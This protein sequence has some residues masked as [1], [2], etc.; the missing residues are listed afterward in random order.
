MKQTSPL[1]FNH[2]L[3]PLMLLITGLLVAWYVWVGILGA[4]LP[5]ETRLPEMPRPK[6]HDRV[7]VFAPHEDDETLGAGAYMRKAVVAGAQVYV[8]LMTAGEGEELGAALATKSPPL[9]P[10]AFIRLGQIRERETRQALALIGVPPSHIFFLDYPNRGLKAMWSATNWA[11]SNPWRSPYTRTAHSPLG[12]CFTPQAPFAGA[13]VVNDIEQVL[14]RVKP[15]QIFTIHPAD[16]HPDHWPT[17]CFV[18]LA[19]EHMRGRDRSLWLRHCPVYTYMVH[20]RGWPAPWGYYPELSLIPP[21]ELLELPINRWL[22]LPLDPYDI[23]TKNR[24]ILTYRSQLARFDMLLR[25]FTRHNEVFAELT[26]IALE[27]R[28][29]AGQRLFLEPT[30]D[31]AMIRDRPYADIAETSL[32]TDGRSLQI[33]VRTVASMN[34]KVKLQVLVHVIDPV[35]PGPRVLEVDYVPGRGAQ[36]ISADDAYGPARVPSEGFVTYEGETATFDLPYSYVGAGRPIMLDVLTSMGRFTTD[37]AITRTIFPPAP[38][39]EGESP[40]LP[41]R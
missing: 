17:Y 22:S 31:S 14:E 21:A 24:M 18:K 13:A 10:R 23:A 15:T 3:T 29:L 38:E 9:S 5:I 40:T 2:D 19:L 39:S 7:L 1:S 32:W 35:A 27:R 26:D 34:Q 36:A 33:R 11:L 16:I 20:H 25:A 37:H 8:C 4:A 28:D 30:A 12:N 41:R 6:Y